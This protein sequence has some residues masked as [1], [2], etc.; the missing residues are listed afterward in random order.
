MIHSFFTIASGFSLLFVIAFVL[1][2]LMAYYQGKE[3]FEI[4]PKNFLAGTLVAI[5]MIILLL[6]QSE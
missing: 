1:L 3:T 4:H 2:M 6:I 5:L